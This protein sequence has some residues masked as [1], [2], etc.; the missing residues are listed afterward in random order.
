[1]RQEHGEQ[2]REEDWDGPTPATT[3]SRAPTRQ[4]ATTEIRRSTATAAVVVARIGSAAP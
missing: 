3:G 1:M 2:G 4:D